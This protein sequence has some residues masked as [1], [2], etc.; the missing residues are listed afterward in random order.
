MNEPALIKQ[1]RTIALLEGWSFLLLL[2]IAMP[3]KYVLGIPLLVKYMGWAHGVLFV[4]YVVWLL[5][6]AIELSWTIGF[7]CWAFIAS[8][9]P[10]G[11]FILDKQLKQRY[12]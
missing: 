10:F 1:F 7:A 9:I 4:L 2:L 12:T 6:S 5:R 8:L 11:P 3:V